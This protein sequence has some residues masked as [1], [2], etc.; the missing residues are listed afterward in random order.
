MDN[1][2]EQ[3]E[4]AECNSETLSGVMIICNDCVD[5]EKIW[6]K[7]T[8]NGMAIL[9]KFYRELSGLKT[10]QASPFLINTYHRSWEGY[11]EFYLMEYN[12][13]FKSE[14]IETIYTDKLSEREMFDKYGKEVNNTKLLEL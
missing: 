9:D 8:H 12:Q 14:Y 11:Y 10:N 2:P 7:L 4:I 5:V 13:I 1:E 6:V 3:L